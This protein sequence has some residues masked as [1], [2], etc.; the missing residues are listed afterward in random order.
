MTEDKATQFLGV[1]GESRPSDIT[2]ANHGLAAAPRPEWLVV[3]N[4]S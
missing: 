2:V 4:Q 3:Q 1:E